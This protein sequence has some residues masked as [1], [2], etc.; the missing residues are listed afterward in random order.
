MGARFRCGLLAVLL[1]GCEAFDNDRFDEVAAVVLATG[2]DAGPSGQMDAGRDAGGSDAGP[3]PDAGMDAGGFDPN[4]CSLGNCWWSRQTP[5]GCSSAGKPT[6]ADR[7]TGTSDQELAPIYMALSR[8]QLGAFLPDDTPDDE[9]WTKFGL[10]LDGVC[11]NAATC[12]ETVDQTSCRTASP[13]IP[14]DGDQCRD[15]TFARLQPVAAMV[16]D[17]G[18]VFGLS[19]D[20]FNCA[21]HNGDYSIVTK[22]SGYNGELDDDAVRLDMYTSVGTEPP[23][24]WECPEENFAATHP[25]WRATHKW[26]IDES[27]LQGAY[28]TEGELPPSSLGTDEAY[29]RGGYIVAMLPPDAII[30]MAGDNALYPGFAVKLQQGMLVGRLTRT[31]EGT[32][33]VRD[34]MLTGRFKNQDL[35]EAFRQIGL[36]PGGPQD[37]YYQSVV[38]YVTETADVLADGE[39]DPERDCD[40]MSVGI[41]FNADPATPGRAVPI[42]E[43]V[44]CLDT[45]PPG[46]DGGT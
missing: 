11:T 31:R 26:L 32:W 20:V 16:P 35:L 25:L 46:A 17:L 37:E 6:M 44:D 29:V 45:M 22:I 24:P 23:A 36:C 3:T 40:A 21:L 28:E 34:G 43:L 30:R 39:T 27:L 15:N 33:N 42:S 41:L 12:S 5:D 18:T 4:S 38:M 19:E 2:M 8:I 14:F 7:P 13:Q 1:L 10:D 9:A